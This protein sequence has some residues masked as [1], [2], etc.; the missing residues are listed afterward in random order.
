MWLKPEDY[1][2]V[3]QILAA[4]RAE[5]DLS[6]KDLAARLR[7]PQSFVSS[8]ENGNRRIDVLELLVIAEGIGTDP[9]RL[10]AKVIREFGAPKGKRRRG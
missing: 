6:Q 2:A 1:T 8:Y 9:A 3:G 5:V 10:F 7:K 4:A